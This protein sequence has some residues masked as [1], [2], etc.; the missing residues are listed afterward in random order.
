[1]RLHGAGGARISIHVPLAGDDWRCRWSAC[2]QRP[3]SIHVPLAGDDGGIFMPK[4]GGT[5]FLSTSPLRGTTFARHAVFKASR[6]SI[7]VP[8]AGDD[9]V[10]CVLAAALPISIHVPLAGDDKSATLENLGSFNFYP[11]PPCGGRHFS[12][13]FHFPVRV[14]L[15]TSP[16]RGTTRRCWRGRWKDETF[17]STSPLRG[18]TPACRIQSFFHP[19][20]IHVPLAGDDHRR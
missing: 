12:P 16:L 4:T 14:F 15:S 10:V 13:V 8:L 5:I 7:H 9:Q 18:T 19:I 17:L 2:R 6:I 1:M 11:R 20:S 3:I